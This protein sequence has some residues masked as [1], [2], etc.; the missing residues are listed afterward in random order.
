MDNKLKNNTS[1]I[2]DINEQY[3]FLSDIGKL[4]T[5]KNDL[6]E[7]I[8]DVLLCIVHYFPII[9]GAI[10][11]NYPDSD[12][13]H[14][15][16][17][18]G[19]APEEIKR[20]IYHPEEG[21]IGKVIDSGKLYAIHSIQKE[22]NFLN[23]TR[24][25]NL[26][27]EDC[28]FICIPIKIHNDVIGTISIDIQPSY[29]KS[30]D[31]I[32]D[33]LVMV[34]FML[35]HVVYLRRESFKKEKILQEENKRLSAKLSKN[36]PK[37][38]VGS[39]HVMQEI[40]EKIMIVSTTNSTV[41]IYGESGTGKELVAF[42][43]HDN[44][45]RRNNSYVALNMAAIPENLI[46]SELFGHEKG[47]FTGATQHRIGK[48]ELANKGTL[49]LDEIADMPMY[50]QPKLLRVLQDRSFE[51]IGSNK[52]MYTDV[53]VIAATNQDLLKKVQNGEFREDLYYRLNV[54]PIFLPPLRNRGSEDII[55]LA[56]FFIDKFSKEFNKEKPGISSSVIDILIHYHWPGNVR[57]L[58]N[59]MQHAMILCNESRIK[60]YHL[61]PSLTPGKN[62]SETLTMNSA[63]SDYTKKMIVHALMT[64]SGNISKAADML[65]TTHRILNYRIKKYGI[66]YKNFRNT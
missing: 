54:F 8:Q 15:D 42:A 62:Q 24:A 36:R 61:P 14:I 64:T 4:F 40:Y 19:Y 9:R 34:S 37:N 21:I 45:T 57:E 1:C 5:T 17:S 39:S 44:S 33:K 38:I 26:S 3:R 29:M 55:L 13:F 18:V 47:A 27:S 49:F 53:R 6:K 10:H 48:F 66:D 22:P 46:E 50:L 51:R 31:N 7:L 35:S 25:R 43:I 41:L 20:G 59:A 52:T 60:P 32:I 12:E 56:D 65:G 28:S 23:K 2:I 11:I 63:I 58:E 16:A 30:Q